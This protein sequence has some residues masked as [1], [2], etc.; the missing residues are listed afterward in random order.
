MKS[1][2]LIIGLAIVFICAFLYFENN[3]IVVTKQ[4]IAS[5]KLPKSF[6]GF[7]IVQVSD[8]HSKIFGKDNK[9][10]TKKIREEKPDIVVI[11]GDF[12]D[13]RRYDE[14]KSMTLIRGLNNEFPIYYVTGNHEGWSGKFTSLE[15]KLLDSGVI[16]MRNTSHKISRGSDSI[17]IAGIDDPAFEAKQHEKEE[18]LKDITSRRIKE[19]IKKDDKNFKVL[20]THRPENFDI[21]AKNNIDLSLAGHAHGGQV[22]LPFV[23][24]LLAPNQGWFPKLTQGV[25]TMGDSHLIVSRGLGNSIVPLRIFNRPELVVVSLKAK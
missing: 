5:K 20:L 17:T 14:E 10:L 22:R 6:D 15:K 2:K 12:I 3:N 18:K 25:H 21:Y 16:V 23:G 4:I 1:K 11:T 9:T 19:A 7:K 8:L 13:R 24:G